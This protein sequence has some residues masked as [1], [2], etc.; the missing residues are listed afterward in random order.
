MVR[1]PDTPVKAFAGMRRSFKKGQSWH[2]WGK[3]MASTHQVASMEI[4]TATN[5]LASRTE[6]TAA[7]MEQQ[8]ASVRQN[9]DTAKHASQVAQAATEVATRGSEAMEQVVSTMELISQSSRKI[10]DIIGVIDGIAFQTNILALHPA[11]DAACADEQ[12]R[13]VATVV[14]VLHSLSRRSTASAKKINGLIGRSVASVQRGARLVG[15]RIASAVS[16]GDQ[17]MPLR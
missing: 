16:M 3:I 8:T 12:R 17:A 9:A 11:V 1:H 7:A 10:G 5:D 6:Q 4:T 13:G 14:T 15:E 2:A